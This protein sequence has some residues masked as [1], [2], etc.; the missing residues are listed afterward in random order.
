M[1]S[2]ALGS[3]NGALPLDLDDGHVGRAH[4]RRSDCPRESSSTVHCIYLRKTCHCSPKT[5]PE[6]YL[7][8]DTNRV[9]SVSQDRRLLPPILVCSS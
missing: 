7:S 9:E 2:E 5:A 3:L 6:R 4:L 8:T 1:Y